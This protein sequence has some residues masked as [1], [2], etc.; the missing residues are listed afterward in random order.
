MEPFYHRHGARPFKF[1]EFKS[2]SYLQ[3]SISCS[4][5][6]VDVF[7]ASLDCLGCLRYRLHSF[8]SIFKTRHSFDV[9]LNSSFRLTHVPSRLCINSAFS[10]Y[11]LCF[12]NSSPSSL[13][14][15]WVRFV[16]RSQRLC[17]ILGVPRF[18]RWITERW[19]CVYT[20]VTTDTAPPTDNLFMN[21]NSVLHDVA[22]HSGGHG[23]TDVILKHIEDTIEKLVKAIKPKTLLFFAIDG[24]VQKG[25][26]RTED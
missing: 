19:P 3:N 20:T 10:Q 5:G 7:L 8:Q 4:A 13:A 18:F 2:N 9:A 1:L 25:D 24:P 11:R 12:F 23:D 14:P 22:V 6:C 16:P 21:L 17:K 15:I 26:S